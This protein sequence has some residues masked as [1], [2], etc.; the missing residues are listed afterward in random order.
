MP[1]KDFILDPSGFVF[2]PPLV[3][4]EAIRELIPQRGAMEQLT[5]IIHDD[6]EAGIVAGFK[7]L[8]DEEFWVPGHMPG[9]PL[10]PGVMMCE[11][12]AQICSYFVMAHDLLGCEMLGFGGLDEVRFRGAVR[13]GDRFVVV[14]QK[15][16]VRRGAMIRC[17]FQCFVG[18]ALVCEGQLRG[19]PIPVEA[20]RA[21][22]G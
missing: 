13:P 6:P 9:M 7:D 3:G 11:A 15:T 1:A 20:L 18:E 8:T 5:G 12:A 2:D 10:M 17:R 14:A 4:I 19:I 16:Q 21:A 22:S